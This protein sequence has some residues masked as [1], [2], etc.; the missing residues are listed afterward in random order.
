MILNN[1][2]IQA[3]RGYTLLTFVQPIGAN[4]SLVD[5][6]SMGT[7]DL[8]AVH[9]EPVRIALTGSFQPE[10]GFCFVHTCHRWLALEVVGGQVVRASRQCVTCRVARESD[11]SVFRC[12]PRVFAWNHPMVALPA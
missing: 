3:F 4:R 2:P 11:R 9:C 6:L 12:P 1:F 7:R 8:K 5:S 10:P